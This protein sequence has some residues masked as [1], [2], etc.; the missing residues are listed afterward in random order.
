M[1]KRSTEKFTPRQIVQQL[2]KYIIGQEDAKKQLAVAYRNKWRRSQASPELQKEIIPTNMLVIG[3]TGTGKTEC[4]RRLANITDA[5]FIKVEALKY[6]E[7]G[8]IGGDVNE[9][10][11]GLADVS[12]NMVKKAKQQEVREKAMHNVQEIILDTLIPRAIPQVE[13]QNPTLDEKG[14]EKKDQNE[15]T[16]QRFRRKLENGELDHYTIEIRIQS[17]SSP[18]GNMGLVGGAMDESA[19]INLE[20][21][22]T[23]MMPKNTKKKKVTIKEATKI[24]LEEEMNNLL[25][26]EAVKEEA[27]QKAENEGIVFIDEIDKIA[28]SSKKTNGPNVS[29]EGVQRDLLPIVEGCPVNTKYGPINTDHILF[30][31]A[32][33]FHIAQPSDLLPEFQ[34]RFPIRVKLEA[35]SKED[36]EKILTKKTSSLIEQYQALFKAEDVTLTF[37]KAAIKEIA[38]LAYECNQKMENIGARRLRTVLNHLL[39]ERLYDVPD[40]IEPGQNVHIDVASVKERLSSLIQEQDTSRYIL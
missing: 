37:D 38:H 36:F 3:P 16:R 29:R 35:L 26:M 39:S 31:A 20:N 15:V 34:G 11:R 21:F 12:F 17:S 9:I 5:P 25:D 24:L 27:R 22:F 4:A 6:T 23:K 19:M 30:I 40:K 10:I 13:N 2:D 14:N 7:R 28:S 18:F 8:Y 1:L 33:A 32:G